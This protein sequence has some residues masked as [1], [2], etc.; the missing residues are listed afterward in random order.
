MIFE[1]RWSWPTGYSLSYATDFDEFDLIYL[2]EFGDH[3]PERHTLQ[4]LKEFVL[5]P[6]VS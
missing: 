1:S 4:Y 3:D 2:A 5:V 6:K